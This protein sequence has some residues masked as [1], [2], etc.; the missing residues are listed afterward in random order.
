MVVPRATGNTGETTGEATAA[1]ARVTART[2]EALLNII[3]ESESTK[4][5]AL[6][7]DC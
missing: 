3:K 5:V 1:T 7:K 6:R 2:R 4:D